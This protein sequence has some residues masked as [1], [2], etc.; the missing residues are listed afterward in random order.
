M[1]HLLT[2]FFTIATIQ[3]AKAQASVQ[4]AVG[5]G[6]DVRVN[7]IEDKRFITQYGTG[8][9]DTPLSIHLYTRIPLKHAFNLCPTVSFSLSQSGTPY[10]DLAGSYVPN[11]NNLVLDYNPSFYQTPN[12]L[13]RSAD[14]KM[15]Q[16]QVGIIFTKRIWRGFELGSGILLRTRSI[17]VTG[18]L[19]YDTY[20]YTG[21]GPQ[22]YNYAYNNTVVE[23]FSS[24]VVSYFNRRELSTP[25]LA[26][27][28]FNY[29]GGNFAFT[30][31]YYF[32]DEN[33]STLRFT[34]AFNLFKMPQRKGWQ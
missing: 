24:P 21:Q 30:Y 32:A 33:F 19:A 28:T 10:L 3:A 29:Q 23:D 16:T 13:Y 14:A 9:A 25:V 31:L 18:S 7:F 2:I 27:Y 11:G 15:Q 34:L 6:F 12:Y 8:N 20:N 5:L 17:T 1:K 26:Q 4:L 22:G